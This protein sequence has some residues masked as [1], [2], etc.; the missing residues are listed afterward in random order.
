MSLELDTR[1]LEKTLR[2]LDKRDLPRVLAGALNK[3]AFEMRDAEAAHV[4]R[5][6]RFSGPSTRAFLADRGFAFRGASPRRL[7]VRLFPRKKTG[8]ILEDHQRGSTISALDGDH[9]AFG[10]KLAIPISVKRGKRGRVPKR[11]HPAE[12]VK[13][14]GRGFVNRRGTVILQRVGRTSSISVLYALVDRARLQPR[15][16]F[17][18]VAFRTARRELP[19]KVTREIQ[20]LRARK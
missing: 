6:F 13:P 16:E 2:E 4:R 7:E 14:G 10:S 12:V 3:T 15:L 19:K 17:F 11:L 9:L 8:E 18:K 20:K 1:S 5:V